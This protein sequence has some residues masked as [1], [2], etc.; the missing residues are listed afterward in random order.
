M[1]THVSAIERNIK[2]ANIWLNELTEELQCEDKEEAWVRLGAVLQT[3][4]DRVPVDEAADFAA[5][6]PVL[7][8]GFYYES[9]N[10]SD[11][12]QKWRHKT[13]YLAAVN[14]KLGLHKPIDAEETVRAVLKIAAH[15][16]D[17][18]AIKKIKES[19]PKEVWDLWPTQ[20]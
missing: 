1:S 20:H 7:I 4:R 19:H 10:P 6:L 18:G 2:M 15:H 12:P 13:D 16:M 3:L 5:Q 14:A 11:T 9:W 17:T 8:R